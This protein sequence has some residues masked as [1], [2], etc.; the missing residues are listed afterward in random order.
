MST[1]LKQLE[2]PKSKDS[3]LKIIGR[4]F[5]YSILANGPWLLVIVCTTIVGYYIAQALVPSEKEVLGLVI[6][7]STPLSLILTAGLQALETKVVLDKIAVGDYKVASRFSMKI[8]AITVI[9]CLI[10]SAIAI[11]IDAYMSAGSIQTGLLFAM[12]ISALSILWVVVAP[13]LGM[14]KFGQLTA[15]FA[16]G[17]IIGYALSVFGAYSFGAWGVIGFQS[18][19]FIMASVGTFIYLNLILKRG[20]NVAAELAARRV[21][22]FK[23]LEEIRSKFERGEI[24][25]DEYK[26][27]VKEFGQLL[28]KIEHDITAIK[29][30]GKEVETSVVKSLKNFMALF[31]ANTLYFTTL[32][33]DR[34]FVWFL[35]GQITA[36]FFIAF[37]VFYE[38]GVNIAQWVLI[39][40]VGLVA[41]LMELFTPNFQKAV[42]GTY[43]VSLPELESSLEKF[44][45]FFKK[46]LLISILV[47]LPI[48][49]LLNVFGVEI[50]SIFLDLNSPSTPQITFLGYQLPTAVF[51]FRIA[52]IG[53]IFHTT[54]ILNYLG[55]M[56]LEQHSL[57]VWLMLSVFLFNIVLC[58]L[59]TVIFGNVY[60]S[61]FGYLV[62]FIIGTILGLQLI[63]KTI[64]EFPFRAY[65][66]LL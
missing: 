12:Q 58:P 59:L 10:T 1:E 36:G 22:L 31:L 35:S 49:I 14:R 44:Y 47:I 62:S 15:I 63:H 4:F 29:S 48:V 56:Y 38:T 19:G 41:V 21:A 65:A 57:N 9:F 25:I 2:K 8:Y 53:V 66:R 5:T 20:K 55:L 11:G 52:T 30:I 28:V 60:Y 6:S 43:R 27:L 26:R 34:I 7:L 16:A 33:A 50:L 18:L 23:I 64:K 45:K 51:V 37:N 17:S 40:G 32:W 39:P 42:E 24:F 13:I 61:I 3:K 46:L 54:T